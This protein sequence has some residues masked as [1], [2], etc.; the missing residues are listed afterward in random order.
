MSVMRRRSSIPQILILTKT[1]CALAPL[2]HCVKIP[3]AILRAS[4]PPR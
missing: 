3:S 1:H 4:A 2:R